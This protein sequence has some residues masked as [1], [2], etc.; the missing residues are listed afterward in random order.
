MANEEC[1]VPYQF[2]SGEEARENG[3]KGGV[4]SGASRRRKRSLKE[5]ADL[6]LSLPVTD[7]KTYN[8]MVLAGVDPDDIDYQMAVVIGMT[9]KAIKGDAKAAKV[10]I[11]MLG[12]TKEEDAQQNTLDKLDSV[13]DEIGGVI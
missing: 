13:L 7:T 10:L 6:F 9:T 11:E 3:R 1:I 5:A 12:G 8:K 2:R 4:N